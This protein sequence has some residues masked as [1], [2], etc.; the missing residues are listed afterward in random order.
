MDIALLIVRLVVGLAF[1]AHGAQ[2]LFG[3]FGGYGLAGTGGFFESLGFKPGKLFAGAAGASE[4]I[5]GLLVVLGLGGPIGPALILATMVVAALTVHFANGFFAPS[6][7]ELNAVYAVLAVLLGVAGFGAFA[8]DAT[9]GMTAVW[10]PAIDW[11]VLGLGVLAGLANVA[12][13]RKPAPQA[14]SQG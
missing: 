11:G 14:A 7:Y 8:L 12:A 10:T 4:F 9:L 1:A 13:R 5:G 2:K 3:W 6:G